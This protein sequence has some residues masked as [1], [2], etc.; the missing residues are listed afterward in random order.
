MESREKRVYHEDIY[1]SPVAYYS[2]LIFIFI[3][4]LS[5]ELGQTPI[6]K[7]KKTTLLHSKM[8]GPTRKHGVDDREDA[9]QIGTTPVPPGKEHSSEEALPQPIPLTKDPQGPD[10]MMYKYRV[11]AFERGRLPYDV[12]HT[13]KPSSPTSQDTEATQA[14]VESDIQ[15]TKEQIIQRIAKIITESDVKWTFEHEN[16]PGVTTHAGYHKSTSKPGQSAQNGKG[17]STRYSNKNVSNE[18]NDDAEKKK[19]AEDEERDRRQKK[20]ERDEKEDRAEGK[21]KWVCVSGILFNLT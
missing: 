3:L 20:K 17:R 2:A 21:G 16:L 8:V 5:P 9:S 15:E 7:F 12:D 18:D 11:S 6:L 1:D 14:I 19:Q 4:R 10:Q 13:T